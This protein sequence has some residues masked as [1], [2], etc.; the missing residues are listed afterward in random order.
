MRPSENLPG[1]EGAMI[2][3]RLMT[4][5]YVPADTGIHY[6]FKPIE[7]NHSQSLCFQCIE[8]QMPQEARQRLVHIYDC[9]EAET[10]LKRIK[11]SKEG[12]RLRP[13]ES[14]FDEAFDTYK[15]KIS[16]TTPGCLLCG[17]EQKDAQYFRARV[18]DR[19]YSGQ[20]PTV[21]MGNVNYSWSNFQEGR[22]DFDICFDDFKRFSRTFGLISYDL[23]GE[24]TLIPGPASEFHIAKEVLDALLRQ[25]MT[26]ESLEREISRSGMTIKLD[27]RSVN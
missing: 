26:I 7:A 12:R 4:L 24:V 1:R 20:H 14:G 16:E 5:L 8:D 10:T 23:G 11:D 6:V 27:K 13:G 22:T 3:P 17:N 18:I 9:Y 21:F 19:A 15:Q 25:G 2:H